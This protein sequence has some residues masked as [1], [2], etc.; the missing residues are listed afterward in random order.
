M[1]IL[2]FTLPIGQNVEIRSALTP[3]TFLFGAIYGFE[4]VIVLRNFTDLR[5]L[6]ASE[7]GNLVFIYHIA[8]GVG[9]KFWNDIDTR[10]EKYILDSIDTSFTSHIS[11]TDKDL[12]GILKPIE[13][14]DI[15]NPKEAGAVQAINKGFQDL[16]QS[17]Y[18]LAQVAPR[19]VGLAEWFMLL[20][21]AGV[22]LASLFF[23]RQPTLLSHIFIGIFASAM[24]STLLLLNEADSNHLQE[25][26]LQYGE[27]NEALKEMEKLPYYPDFAIKKGV[28]APAK[29]E[30]Y[31]LGT[32]PKYP[33]LS[34]REIKH[35]ES[36]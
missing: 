9:G 4:I 17:R 27:Y 1:L 36:A 31:R 21:L 2:S 28:V 32:F 23:L 20:L 8:K 22:I 30:K 33:D 13:S 10:I 7:I 26:L 16:L 15:A 29:G 24:L 12:L 11:A 14:I 19:E 35:M 18:K 6:L 3:A 25:A 5:Q 34:V